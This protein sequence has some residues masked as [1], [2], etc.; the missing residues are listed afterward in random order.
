LGSS[1]IAKLETEE[2]RVQ[3]NE[4]IGK[5]LLKLQS[6]LRPVSHSILQDEWLTRWIGEQA[7][8]VH[9]G[10]WAGDRQLAAATVRTLFEESESPSTLQLLVRRV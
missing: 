2:V 4:L 7:I 10:A 5:S 6:N 1:V 3:L 9:Y 8:D